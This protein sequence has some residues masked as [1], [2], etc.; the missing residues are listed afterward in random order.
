MSTKFFGKQFMTGGTSGLVGS[1]R[2]PMAVAH[3]QSLL[4]EH[5][6]SEA[7]D[8]QLMLASINDILSSCGRHLTVLMSVNPLKSFIE[9]KAHGAT[10]RS[11]FLKAEHFSLAASSVRSFGTQ[12]LEASAIISPT[13]PHL[14]SGF[15]QS[16]S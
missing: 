15:W 9:T 16:A 2:S 4:T 11:S 7:I 1:G 10:Q 14:Q 12:M 13:L 6:V 8:P 3:L 5:A